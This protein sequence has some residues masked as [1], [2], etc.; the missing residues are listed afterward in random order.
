MREYLLGQVKRPQYLLP[1]QRPDETTGKIAEWWLERWVVHRIER[2]DV[3][4]RVAGHTMV[5]PIRHGARVELP[6]VDLDQPRLF[7]ASG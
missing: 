7:D 4:E 2:D 1:K 6:A 5:L 3:L